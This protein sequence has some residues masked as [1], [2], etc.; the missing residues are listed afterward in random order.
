[1]T[2]PHLMP[3]VEVVASQWTSDAVLA[4]TNALMLRVGQVPVRVKQE[5]PGFVLNRL[6]GAMLTEMFELISADVISASDADLIISQGLGLRWA[7]LG[8]IEG[9]D[10]NAPTGVEGY[11]E[12]YGHIFNDM[13]AEKGLPPPV[14]ANLIQR[15]HQEMRAQLRVDQLDAKRGWRDETIATILLQMQGAKGHKPC[16]L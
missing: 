6:Q 15:L 10:L 13:A 7:T 9:V 3:V 11:L 2:P 4:S 16:S 12:R 8:P 1:M 14:N 5:V